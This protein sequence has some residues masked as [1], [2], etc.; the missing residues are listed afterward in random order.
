VTGAGPAL[1]GVVVFGLVMAGAVVPVPPPEVVLAV[2]PGC[3][4]VVVT[5]PAAGEAPP[6]AGP[7]AGKVVALSVD[8]AVMPAGAPWE[9]SRDTDF[10]PEPPEQAATATVTPR[11]RAP[12]V[13]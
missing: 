12:T 4:F 2:V 5:P 10:L 1:T 13:S 8:P 6:D 11:S 9:M 7:V 3:P